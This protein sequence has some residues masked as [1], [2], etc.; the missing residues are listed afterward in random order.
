M[1]K[2]VLLTP[3]QPSSNP[4][5]V[6]EAISLSKAGY[7][8][9]VIYCFWVQW[10][11][12]QDEALIKE[13][14]SIEWVRVGGHPK[15]KK[16]TYWYTRFRHKLYRIIASKRKTSAIWQQRAIIRCYD[17]L[18]HAAS[19]V[20]ADLYIAHNIGALAPAAIAAKKHQSIY[21]FDAEDYHRGE[22]PNSSFFYSAIVAIENKYLPQCAYFTAASP[23]IEAT[24]KRLYP[25]KKSV[26]INNVFS[27]QFLQPTDSSFDSTINLFWF[28]QTVGPNR[29]LEIVIQALNQLKGYNFTL[30]ILGLCSDVYKMELHKSTLQPSYLKFI[31][32]ISL[33]GI[34]EIASKSDIGL[35]TEVP[36]CENREICLTNK[37]FIYLLSGNCIVAS[38]TTAQQQFMNQYPGVGV[39]YKNNDSNDLSIQLKRL[40]DDR[41]LLQNFRKNARTLADTEL[42]WEKESEKLIQLIQSLN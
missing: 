37:L 18:K 10:A 22:F 21:A 24:Y 28:S 20:M 2:I 30:H 42:N 38:D 5:I 1:K 6:K 33:Q 26:V 9:T 41:S 11:D 3:G 25:G 12:K 39:L 15:E 8:V 13:N 17:E 40:F 16:I 31:A 34:F 19:R 14:P 7:Y 27:R 32:P 29:G 35:A 23:L 36:Y 4:R